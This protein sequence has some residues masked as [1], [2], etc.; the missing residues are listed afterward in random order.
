MLKY[1]LIGYIGVFLTAIAQVTLKYGAIKKASSGFLTFFLN[2]YTLLGYGLMF[3]I[4][5]I[6]LYIYKYLDIKYALIF[7]PSSYILVFLF[8]SVILKEK[9]D[10]SKIIQYSIILLGVIIFNL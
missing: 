2:T 5:L 6:N 8:S 3:G 1:F 7:L 10:R 9:I 4:T